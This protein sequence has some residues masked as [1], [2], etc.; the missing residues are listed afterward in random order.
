MGENDM[1]EE[2]MRTQKTTTVTLSHSDLREAVFDFISERSFGQVSPDKDSSLEVID[3]DGR[4]V[5]VYEVRVGC[6]E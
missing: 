1:T 2:D 6:G 5:S 4:V 3:D